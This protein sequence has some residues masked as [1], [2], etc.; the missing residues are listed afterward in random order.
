MHLR[1]V[2]RHLRRIAAPNCLPACLA[3]LQVQDLEVRAANASAVMAS[4]RD[5]LE[6]LRAERAGLQ[7]EA[8]Q[9]AAALA[10]S[11]AQ[12]QALAKRN[13]ELRWVWV[14]GCGPNLGVKAALCI[15]AARC[16]HIQPVFSPELAALRLRPL[17][18]GD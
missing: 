2:H 6:G 17:Q 8:Q 16:L 4:N 18:P 13:G 9:L 12:L 10:D 15:V 14:G 1:A 7:G 5:Q 3:H 11:E